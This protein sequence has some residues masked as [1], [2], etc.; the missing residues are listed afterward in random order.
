MLKYFPPM[1]GRS[2][3]KYANNGTARL[4]IT[5]SINILL[6]SVKLGVAT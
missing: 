1:L 2:L 5:V 6:N 3:L 4:H